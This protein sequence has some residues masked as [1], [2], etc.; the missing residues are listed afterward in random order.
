MS[1][2][3]PGHIKGVTLIEL[4]IVLVLAGILLSVAVPAFQDILRRQRLRI[5]TND[6]LA[7]IDLT[8]SQAIARG[9]RVLM[10]PIAI[11]TAWRWPWNGRRRACTS[12]RRIRASAA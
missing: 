10:A 9:S 12:P 8:R 4:L 1:R 5:A 2:Q 7:A 11:P 6:L 3:Y